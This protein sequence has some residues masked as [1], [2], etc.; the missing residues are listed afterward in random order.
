[1]TSLWPEPSPPAVVTVRVAVK[2]PPDGYVCFGLASVL[3][4]PSPKSQA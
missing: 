2:S 3:V 1:M 4:A